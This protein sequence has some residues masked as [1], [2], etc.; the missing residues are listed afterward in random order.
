M[1]WESFCLIWAHATRSPLARWSDPGLE[2]NSGPPWAN[3]VVKPVHLL[4]L[5]QTTPQTWGLPPYL[6]L[7]TQQAKSPPRH[8]LHHFVFI[9]HH[10]PFCLC[11]RCPLGPPHIR[12]LLEQVISGH[13]W[14]R[15]TSQKVNECGPAGLWTLLSHMAALLLTNY[16]R[17][18]Q[19][20]TQP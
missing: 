19:T 7:H 15:L 2:S 9:C 5:C 8:S 20:L 18:D 1:C 12:N 11:P 16:A 4:A 13:Y 14:R 17:S 10:P 3:P 6:Q